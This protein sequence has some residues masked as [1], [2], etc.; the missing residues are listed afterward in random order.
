M[1]S[2][3]DFTEPEEDDE[4]AEGYAKLSNWINLIRQFMGMEVERCAQLQI[5]KDSPRMIMN[6]V[7]E[8]C[9]EL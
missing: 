3:K 7:G 2:E 5:R 9:A 4:A 1:S 8:L 6:S